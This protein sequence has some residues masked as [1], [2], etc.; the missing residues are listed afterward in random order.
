MSRLTDYTFDPDA[1]DVTE[2]Q[3]IV[4]GTPAPPPDWTSA[5]PTDWSGFTG[6]QKIQYFNQQGIT[7]DQLAPYATPEEIQYFYNNMGYTVG[8]PAPNPAPTAAPAAPA[9]VDTVTAPAAAASF[10]PLTFD[11]SSWAR[12]QENIGSPS[13]TFDG[14][15]Y[16][17]V[18]YEQG[19]GEDYYKDYGQLLGITKASVDSKPGDIL[20]NID[21]VTGQINQWQSEKDRG[22]FGGLASSFSSVATD[23]APLILTAIGIPGSGLAASIGA[24]A[25]SALGISGLSAASTAALGSAVTNAALTAAQGGSLQDVLK[26]AAASGLGNIAAEQIA[27]FAQTA[28]S[29][30][31]GQLGSDALGRAV[32]SGITAGAGALPQAV[33][34]G[35][36]GN[37]LTSALTAGATSGIT[38]GMSDLTGFTQPQI[39]AAVNIAQGA[40]S[41]DL[42][43]ILTG[44]GAF[45]DSPIP[46][47]ASKAIAL[48]S[49]V[50]SGN[51][52]RIAS[53]MQGFGS[54]MDSYNNQQA[55]DNS[56]TD[57]GDE[58]ARLQN[59]FGTA[60][61]AATAAAYSDPSRS[62]DT[63]LG[64]DI[65]GATMQTTAGVDLGNLGLTEPTITAGELANIVSGG[66]TTAST[67]GPYDKYV[68][69][70]E[71]FRAARSELGN[72]KAFTWTDPISGA[73]K[74]YTTNLAPAQVAQ[75]DAGAGRGISPG[76]TAA[77]AAALSSIPLGGQTAAPASPVDPFV[78][79]AVDFTD[80]ATGMQGTALD[81][82][83]QPT[84][85]LRDIESN[86]RATGANVNRA[87]ETGIPIGI[88]QLAGTGLRVAEVVGSGFGAAPS[89]FAGPTGDV[90]PLTAM[91]GTPLS[92]D[93]QVRDVQNQLY[94][95]QQAKFAALPDDAQRAAAAGIASTVNTFGTYALG[96]A[97]LM[98][99]NAAANTGNLA[100][101]E[102]KRAGLSDADAGN[103]AAAMSAIELA[104]EYAGLPFIKMMLRGAPTSGGADAVL[105]YVKRNVT[106]YTGEN[107]SELLTTAGQF[108]VDRFAQEGIPQ[109]AQNFGAAL[110][111][112]LITT[113]FAFGGGK[114]V[115]SFMGTPGLQTVTTQ[116][117]PTPIEFLGSTP[118]TS[119]V[120]TEG[121]PQQL[122]YQPP[123]P[124]P[125][126]VQISGPEAAAPAPE[127]FGPESQLGFEEGV[128]PTAQ[129]QLE[130][131]L[132]G[133]YEPPAPP[134]PKPT[135]P[136]DTTG[137][138]PEMVAFIDEDGGIVTY[139]DLG[140][141]AP[142]PAPAAAPQPATQTATQAQPATDAIFA[143]PSPQMDE[144]NNLLQQIYE[145]QN[146]PV[147]AVP[148][149][150]PTAAPTTALTAAPAQQNVIDLAPSQ[151]L[152][153]AAP[154]QDLSAYQQALNQAVYGGTGEE[155][156]TQAPVSPVSPAPAATGTIL[157]TDPTQGTALVAGP[158]GDTKVVDVAPDAK[159]GDTVNIGAAPAPSPA[160]AA[161]AMD[162]STPIA[163]DPAT[164][165]VIRL[166]DVVPSTPAPSTTETKTQAPA[167][168][169]T[170]ITTAAPSPAP[171]T[172][173]TK[174]EAPAPAPTTT[175][176]RTPSP[177]PAPST[178][179]TKTEAPA[180][181]PS[182]TETKTE[183]PAPAPAPTTT[184]TKTEAPAPAPTTQ[185]PTAAPPPSQP[186]AQ[187]PAQPPSQPPAQP[188]AQPPTPAQPAGTTPPGEDD[189][190]PVTE[191]ELRDIVSGPPPAPTPAPP[192]P[193]PAQTPAPTPRPTPAPTVRPP[194]PSP[195]P[196]AQ[197]PQ[198]TPEVEALIKQILMETDEA[199]LLQMTTAL[200]AEREE[201]REGLRGKLK[202]RKA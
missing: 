101:I 176:V 185:A 105:D 7:P 152:T 28:G 9:A 181:A 151:T 36:F 189:L 43:K 120:P 169:Q 197:S 98:L 24:S 88:T 108:A 137:I 12:S 186:P 198:M 131:A 81:P 86:L 143:E 11:W 182:T 164:G 148:A 77:D 16:T 21:P 56:K 83:Y 183:A 159:P 31:A 25:A 162:L 20:E 138:T 104:G 96:G 155:P 47:L 69:F 130:E 1:A 70:G 92:A 142:S 170:A 113:A 109:N 122:T 8:A 103:R 141:T 123:A 201:K 191:E 117:E 153:T 66:T 52:A 177:A 100:W 121:L 54:A 15:V 139:G 50:E 129:Q 29:Q 32:T 74:T 112:T 140:V 163:T 156:V 39:N 23:L 107:V 147:S 40:A 90:D 172:T 72:G 166:G 65:R 30:I 146:Y 178:T 95:F 42:S 51:P 49:A 4:G 41:G 13:Q 102:G 38:A 2:L 67:Q 84:T 202:S 10:N 192:A 73:T 44:V 34:S 193:T 144:I 99:A 79:P 48:K 127:V 106:A 167:P 195:P 80:A 188:P 200:K 37:V 114:A 93:A 180:P 6:D 115:G 160:P 57:T 19:S 111:N 58:I 3:Q 87:I 133:V 85:T 145:Q 118:Q 154:A 135:A 61:D 132:A 17:P 76:A 173:E 128:R 71:A 187:P 116:A 82:S 179:E 125:S 60:S 63:V 190:P 149:T 126:Q 5:V 110:G 199:D 134:A 97:P 165:E 194:S 27:A 196:A 158:N 78:N 33:I 55:R 168:S 14:I 171:S 89:T 124:P 22:F 62:L 45:T 46:G 174:T 94:D 150:A 35:D 68:T 184:E 119:I 157:S 136:S 91:Q 53:A 175:E 26:A 75:V 161:P 64:G 18:F 59:R